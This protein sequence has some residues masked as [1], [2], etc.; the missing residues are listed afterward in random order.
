MPKRIVI[1]GAGPTGLGAAYR[2]QELGYKNWAIYE[3]NNYVGGLSA[4]FKDKAGFTWDIGGHVI[5]SHYKYFDDLFEK[6]ME[7]QYREHLRESWIKIAENWLPY[8]FQNN[9]KYLPKDKILSCLCGLLDTIN[10]P[11]NLENFKEWLY[12]T[13]GPEMAETFF[14]PDNQ[15]R[16]CYPLEKMS[17]DWIKD[18]VSVVDL[19]R[20]LRNI[21][22][23]IDDVGWGP[24]SKFKYPLRGGTGGFFNRFTPLIKDKLYFNKKLASVDLKNKKVYFA[25]RTSDS[26]DFLVSTIPINILAKTIRDEGLQKTAKF[27]RYNSALIVG[28]GIK[29]LCPS[30]KCWIYFPHRDVSYF[31]ITYLS[32]YSPYNAPGNDYYSLMC[33]INYFKK[34][35]SS[36]GKVI[37]QVIDD[38]IKTQSINRKDK[39]D[40]ISRYLVDVEYAYPI[41]TLDRDKILKYMQV[42]L[43]KNSIFSRGR[44]GSWKYEIGNI[45]HCLMQGVEIIERLVLGKSEEVWSL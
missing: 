27:L 40:I 11:S 32:N 45:D 15:K 36:K 38:L 13:F 41:P 5:H 28:V 23:D 29:Q 16:W 7:K 3:A 25:D 34:S 31:R 43:E 19:K 42:F 17:F 12:S 4:S 18:R 1:I 22:L 10:S 6:L 30:K 9:I 35:I 8:P 33:E 26:Y 37:A 44:F 24:N 2:L 14:I 20:I 21:I 39:K